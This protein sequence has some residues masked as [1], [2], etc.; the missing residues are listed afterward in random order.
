[1]HRTQA[2]NPCLNAGTRKIEKNARGRLKTEGS[3]FTGGKKALQKKGTYSRAGEKAAFQHTGTSGKGRNGENIVSKHARSRLACSS[4]SVGGRRGRL[5][6]GNLRKRKKSQ[7]H[8]GGVPPHSVYQDTDKT[9][10]W[11][12]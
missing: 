1:M 5:G 2:S 9:R 3:R 12:E 8:P 4:N 7:R 6:Q 11:R 10:P